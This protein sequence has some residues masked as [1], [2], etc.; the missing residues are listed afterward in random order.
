MGEIIDFKPK[1]SEQL[2][3][4]ILKTLSSDTLINIFFPGV[5]DWE[6]IVI[7][8]TIENVCNV[9]KSEVHQHAVWHA[10]G[11][12]DEMRKMYPGAAGTGGKFGTP[13]R[14]VDVQLGLVNP[15]S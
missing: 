5:V 10:L 6:T 4:A 9:I 2:D 11:Q 14:L 7:Q 13:E 12:F 8:T 15:E 3:G 1:E